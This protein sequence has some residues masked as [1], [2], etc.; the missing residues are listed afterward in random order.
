M[1]PL[2]LRDLDLSHKATN[3]ELPNEH[4]TSKVRQENEINQERRA[5]TISNRVTSYQRS[6][7][8]GWPGR[9]ADF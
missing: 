9:S 8:H 4:C 7:L 2:R 6:G 1:W 3:R 5:Q